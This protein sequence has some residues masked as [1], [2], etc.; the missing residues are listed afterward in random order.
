R[1][2]L[3][4]VSL[5]PPTLLVQLTRMYNPSP[6]PKKRTGA[7]GRMSTVEV[8]QEP[9][10]PQAQEKVRKCLHCR[11]EFT[12]RWYGERVCRRCKSNSFW[13]GSVEAFLEL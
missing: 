1:T 9:P 6:E 12:S 11:G 13:R 4:C 5:P 8:D 3:K 10:A 7:E 2:N